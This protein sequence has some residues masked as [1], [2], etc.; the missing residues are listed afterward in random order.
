MNAGGQQLRD[1]VTEADPTNSNSHVGESHCPLGLE[2]LGYGEYTGHLPENPQ[3]NQAY[4]PIDIS[5]RGSNALQSPVSENEAQQ[6]GSY[7][8]SRRRSRCATPR[9]EQG[10]SPQDVYAGTVT[11][12]GQVQAYG[13]T[14]TLHEPTAL[15]PAS[16]EGNRPE[17]DKEKD[18]RIQLVRD[19]LLSNA[20][21]QR[22]R[23]TSL[24]LTPQVKEKIDLDGVAPDVAFHLMNLHWNRQHYSYLL[25]YRPAIMDSLVNGGPYTNKL[26]LNAIYYSSSLYSDRIYLRADPSE[27]STLRGRFYRRFKELLVDEID[28]PSIPTAVALLLCGASLVSHGEQ[29]AGWVLCGTAYRMIIDLGCH[30]SMEEVQQPSNDKNHNPSRSTA[31]EFEIRKRLYWGAFMT[32]KFQ[33]LYLGR[34]P[35]LRSTDAHPPK[36]IL[37]CYEELELWEPYKGLE[38]TAL[39][40]GQVPYQ[41]QPAYAVSTFSS[42][43]ELAEIAGQVIDAFYSKECMKTPTEALQQM[44]AKI[45]HQLDEWAQNLPCHLHFN[46]DT[47]PTPPPH[48]I[49]PQYVCP[50]V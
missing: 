34:A 44:K 12:D 37:D 10:P 40:S 36:D 43:L 21:I 45:G 30:L 13:V 23:E 7:R 2:S 3:L 29:S 5:N 24:H 47:C 39:E 17:N 1:Q 42:L 4:V 15:R 8:K 14:S 50:A 49:P 41:T 20:V 33:S 28:R 48:Q 38:A 27:T 26:L 11:K 32:D 6:Q 35:A 19:Q 22:Q 18:I 9:A 46:P 25:T 16:E 31:I